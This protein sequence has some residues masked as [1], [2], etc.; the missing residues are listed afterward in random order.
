[1]SL[2]W[3]DE[4]QTGAYDL[5]IKQIELFD[6]LN[7]FLMALG[8]KTG[9]P[10][11]C[12]NA[13]IDMTFKFIEEYMVAHFD[14]EEGFIAEHQY[15]ETETHKESHEVFKTNLGRLKDK[16]DKRGISTTLTVE[17]E[18]YFKNWLTDHILTE[19]KAFGDFLQ[20]KP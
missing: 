12:T 9:N 5:D 14:K 11:V 16:F 17:T 2:L 7:A 10:N 20:K 13:D 18:L 1:M 6:R 4:L 8:Y 19:D 15:P 3:V